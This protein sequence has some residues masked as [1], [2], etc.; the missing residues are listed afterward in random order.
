MN[1][2]RLQSAPARLAAW[3]L[4]F[5]VCLIATGCAASPH[6]PAL[7]TA[8][9]LPQLPTRVQP[10][11]SLLLTAT[12]Q[13]TVAPL[14]TPQAPKVCSPLAVQPLDRIKEIVTQPF[15]MP[16]SLANGTYTDDAHHGVDLGYYTRDG[17]N[18]T[19]TPV[20]AAM[21]GKIAAII[22]NRYPY[23]NMIMLETR[24]ADL[25]AY[26]IASQQIPAGDSLYSLYA[27][28][29]NMQAWSLGQEVKCG[30]QLAET[31]LTGATGGPH[32]H[33]ET[34]WGPP[35]ATFAVMGYY[36]ADMSPDELKNYALWRMSGTFRLFDPLQL[37][38]PSAH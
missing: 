22:Q 17:H 7:Q 34:R 10:P 26:I 35:D 25:P 38:A 2:I 12:S 9:A 32:L 13:A 24:Y 6:A 20:L 27:H 33:F 4:F 36:K 1:K 15:S 3:V 29:Q 14:L 30:Q 23:G 28:L 37:F 11:A 16:R 5:W 21:D 8:T 31:G 18:F 19:G